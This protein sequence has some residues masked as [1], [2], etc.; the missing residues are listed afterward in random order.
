MGY[1]TVLMMTSFLLFLIASA[2]PVDLQ[3]EVVGLRT[4][5]RTPNP[6]GYPKCSNL[7]D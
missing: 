7:M 5:I 1:R 6:I 4:P 2:V 3:T